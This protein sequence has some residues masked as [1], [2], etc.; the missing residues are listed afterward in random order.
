MDAREVLSDVPLFAAAL[1]D[2]QLGFLAGQSRPAFFRAGTRLM[3]QG[4]FGGSMFIIVR[5]EVAVNFADQ[6]ARE[7][8]VA[9]LGPKEIVGEMSLF[10]GDRRTATVSAV[11]NVDALEITKWSLERIFMQAPDLIDR[12]GEMLALRQAELNALSASRTA[13]SREA[14]VSQARKAFAGI[15]GGR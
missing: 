8:R 7:R 3:S 2:G 4:D 12:F 6:D 15:F 9:T 11:T 5:G 1:D 13:A 10:T 14:F